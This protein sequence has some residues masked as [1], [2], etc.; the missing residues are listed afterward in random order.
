MDEEPVY[1]IIL[2]EFDGIVKKNLL[3]QNGKYRQCLWHTASIDP[4]FHCK[5]S[6]HKQKV[7]GGT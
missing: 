6:F 3:N 7:L 2:S 4:H 1:L 5:N